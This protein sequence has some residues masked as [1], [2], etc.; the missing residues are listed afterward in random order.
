MHGATLF[1]TNQYTADII[2]FVNNNK[3]YYYDAVNNVEYELIAADLPANETITFLS[4]R[5]YTVAAPNFDYLTIG[6]YLNGTYKLY[7]YIMIGGKPNGSPVR[8]TSGTGKIKETHYLGT[9]FTDFDLV[10]GKRY[11]R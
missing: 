3:L 7:M 2:Y 5:Q 1:A 4:N 10:M 9:S 11:S 8:T 6:T